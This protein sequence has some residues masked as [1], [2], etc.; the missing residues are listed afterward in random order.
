[1][2]ERV[3]VALCTYN[4]SR[5][6]KEQLDSIAAQT[7]RPYELVA[8][9]DGS[10][11]DTLAQLKAFAAA[12]P[13]PVRVV[14]NETTLGSTKNF[15]QAVRLCGGDLIALADQDDVWRPD[16]LERIG[17]RLSA[18]PDVGAVF[19]DADVV[20]E[21]LRSSGCRLWET[22]GFGEEL[23][24]KMAMGRGF[25]VLLRRNVATG[26]TMV[27]RSR[28]RDLVLPIPASWVH[29]GWIVLLIAAVG[30]VAALPEPLILYRQ[31]QGQQIGA[32]EP[33]LT[34][35][36]ALL[37]SALAE[38]FRDPQAYLVKW[39]DDFVSYA[40][41]YRLVSERLS[42]SAYR[43]HDGALSRCR[44]K[45]LHL[46][47]RAEMSRRPWLRVPM[48]ISEFVTGRYHRHT[49]GFLGMGRDLVRALFFW[50]SADRGRPEAR[51][52]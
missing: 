27:F 32:T 43:P 14:V 2:N 46:T 23:Q 37:R 7:H 15:E 10:T 33:N 44:S 24:R 38:A 34:S 19:T 21:S 4:G 36:G 18:D 28:F 45:V 17:A 8:C 49:S 3:S 41:R 30:R 16:K 52:V 12:T 6:L 51:V 48:V 50:V 42:S 26:A 35:K 47:R 5:Y 22:E 9:D 11:D 20:D 39:D 29:D 1:M 40:D 31:H 25:D 13:F